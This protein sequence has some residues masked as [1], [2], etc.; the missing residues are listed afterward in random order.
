MSILRGQI[1]VDELTKLNDEAID[2]NE[3]Y[4]ALAGA[5]AEFQRE[6]LDNAMVQLGVTKDIVDMSQRN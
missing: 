5:T 4:S 2:S 6:F 3:E 1:P